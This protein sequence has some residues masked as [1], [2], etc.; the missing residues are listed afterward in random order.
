MVIGGQECGAYFVVVIAVGA[1]VGR[2]TVSAAAIATAEAAEASTGASTAAATEFCA[3]SRLRGNDSFLAALRLHV[4]AVVGS[5]Q[6][7]KQKVTERA[8]ED[9]AEDESPV[10]HHDHEH[11]HVAE[12][13]ID[14]VDQRSNGTIGHRLLHHTNRSGAS[15]AA[16]AAGAATFGQE[17]WF[18]DRD[19]RHG[20]S[21]AIGSPG[22]EKFLDHAQHY[23][24]DTESSILCGR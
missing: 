3:A 21:E 5:Q 22:K 13:E 24:R 7:R 11:D 15:L 1:A 23:Q 2:S 20:G 18:T 10:V 4:L 6:P 16:A 14:G 17:V 19:R 8:P 12:E 9:D